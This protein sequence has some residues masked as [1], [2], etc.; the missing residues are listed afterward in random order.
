MQ[1]RHNPAKIRNIARVRIKQ[2]QVRCSTFATCNKDRDDCRQAKKRPI[3]AIS[4]ALPQSRRIN[5]VARC[6]FDDP[7]HLSAHDF[8]RK[9]SNGRAGG[10][11]RTQSSTPRILVV[12]RSE[13]SG[14][15]SSCL[16][17]HKSTSRRRLLGNTGSQI[18]IAPSPGLLKL[19]RSAPFLKMLLKHVFHAFCRFRES[20]LLASDTRQNCGLGGGT[21]HNAI[22]I[23]AALCGN[24]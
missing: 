4:G 12:I 16:P 23:T 22:S 8:L 9:V 7:A 13:C 2:K 14:S 21:G 19:R 5:L 11:M 1:D 17:F 24:S 15:R 18:S 6:L 20:V 3:L 10:S